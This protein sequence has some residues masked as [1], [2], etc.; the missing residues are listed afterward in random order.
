MKTLAVNESPFSRKIS[1][2][3]RAALAYAAFLL[4]AALFKD[5][6]AGLMEHFAK[7]LLR[8]VRLVDPP[9]LLPVASQL[10]MLP[11]AHIKLQ[12]VP[13]DDFFLAVVRPAQAPGNHAAQVMV[14]F[15]QGGVETFT[16]G[17]NRGD[18]AAGGA[19]VDH[20]IEPMG[21]AEQPSV[22]ASRRKSAFFIA[23]TANS[24]V[25]RQAPAA[26]QAALE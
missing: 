7:D 11:D 22:G 21:G 20:N 10:I 3:L 24:N 25:K 9:D 19:A 8:H 6:D 14:G 2:D 1:A 26:P 18:H 12:R 17:G 16:S 4:Q 15:E 23:V 13:A 5:V